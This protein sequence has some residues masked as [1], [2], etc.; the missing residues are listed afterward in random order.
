MHLKKVVLILTAAIL[1]LTVIGCGKSHTVKVTGGASSIKQNTAKQT[2][3][4]AALKLET[5]DGAPTPEENDPH[6]ETDLSSLAQLENL[7]ELKLTVSDDTDIDFS[8]LGKMKSL[9]KLELQIGA[10][11]AGSSDGGES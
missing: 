7:K 10:A 3:Q 4:P 2:R 8:F 5:E 6:G 11:S 1:A 9:E